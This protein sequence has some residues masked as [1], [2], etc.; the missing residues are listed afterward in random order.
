V[1]AAPTYAYIAALLALIGVGFARV[2]TGDVPAAAAPL[3]PFPPEG[4][5]ALSALLVLRAF[6]SGAVGLTGSEAVA[7]GV[8]NFKPPEPRN[9]VITLV[10]MASIFA[11]IFLGLSWL[12][13]RIGVQ[14]DLSEVETLNSILTRSI[15]GAGTP[16]YYFVQVTTAVI[17]LLAA[18]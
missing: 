5:T 1:F 12:A 7:N 13:T 2:L 9:A 15:V 18:N 11:T 4:A 10:L 8:P 6:A 17:L 16:F 14:P 3:V